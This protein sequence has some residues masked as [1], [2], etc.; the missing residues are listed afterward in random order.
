LEK[1]IELKTIDPTALLGVGDMNVKLIEEMIPAKII[2]RGEKI[3]IQG[4]ELDVIRA[5]EVLYEM[6]QTL[7]TR[8]ELNVRDIQQLITLSKTNSIETIDIHKS[9]DSIIYFGKK[10]AV[11]PKTEG[12]YRYLNTVKDNDVVFSIGPAGT[13]KTF[14]SVAFA[15]AALDSNEVDRIILCRP[16]VEAGESLGFLPGDLKDKVDPYLAPLYDS[17]HTLYSDSKLNR[18]LDNKVIEVVP[19][20]YMR[21]RT[22]DNAYMILDEAQN[23]TALQMKMF[24]TRLGVGSRAIITGDITQVDLQDHERSGLLQAS[25]ILSGVEGIG[26]VR[27]DEK[28]VVRHPLVKKIIQA[29]DKE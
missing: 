29:Y 24:L 25:E 15:L 3:K 17:L 26:F 9:S 12:Q 10:G 13:G 7:G 4:E 8:G 6:M 28:D 21:G 1:V 22:L 19:L 23:A 20:A 5:S 11:S 2:A 27:L 18:Y 16:A 14:L